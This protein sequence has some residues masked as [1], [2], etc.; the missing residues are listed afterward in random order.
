MF[1]ETNE[2]PLTYIHL[3][4]TRTQ[5]AT[6][7]TPPQSPII[8]S[9]LIDKM[10]CHPDRNR[11]FILL[12]SKQSYRTNQPTGSS[13]GSNRQPATY[14]PQ[15]SEQEKISAAVASTLADLQALNTAA[16]QKA[17]ANEKKEAIR[18]YLSE[19]H[20]VVIKKNVSHSIRRFLAEEDHFTGKQLPESIRKVLPG[21]FEEKKPSTG[22]R[23][24]LG[25]NINI[26]RP[27]IYEDKRD[28]KDGTKKAA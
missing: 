26:A 2:T 7:R 21:S 5:Q 6:Q 15:Q 10:V 25:G 17:M 1:P 22:L 14:E 24:G 4:S 23:G 8:K 18:R 16:S 9:Q 28:G 27:K 11:R 20:P 3:S 12:T 13:S 19:N